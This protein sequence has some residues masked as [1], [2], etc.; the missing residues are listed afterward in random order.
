MMVLECG[1]EA[2]VIDAGLM[3]PEDY[4]FGVDMVL[5]D[6]SY[7]KAKRDKIRAIILTHGH[8][9]H[10]GALP[11]FLEEFKGI[12]IYGTAFT[13]GLLQEKLR[14]QKGGELE[15][16]Y[17]VKPR[18]RV[19]FGPMEVEF[20]RV[21]HS[22]PDCVG[23]GIKTPEGYI[24]HSGDFKLDSSA[25][26]TERTDLRKFAEYGEK[27]VALLLS[28]STNADR[29]GFS[30]SE[31]EVA[32]KLE[33]I[34][35]ERKGRVIVALFAS[36]I[37]RI[38][39]LMEIAARTGR[40]VALVGKNVVANSRLAAELDYLDLPSDGL[41]ELNGIEQAP[42][43]ELLIITTGSQAEPMSALSL[44]ASESHKYLKVREGDTIVLSS[45]FIP[46]NER[47]ITHMIN[48]LCRLGAEVIYS[49]IA[50]VHASGHAHRKELQLL[51]SLVQPRYLLPVHGEYRHLVA[52]RQLAQEMGMEDGRVV[53]AEDGQVIALRDG[54]VTLEGRVEVGKVFV[55]GK[56]IGDVED[57][58][59]RDRRHL[60]EDGMVVPIM[61]VKEQTG[62][63][64]SGPD[65]ITKGVFFEE[66]GGE[67]LERAKERLL[68]MWREITETGRSD[69]TELEEEVRR[70]LKRFFKKEMGR[71]PV[72]IPVIIGM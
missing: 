27:G 46:G 41:V 3:F 14:D 71:R 56:G 62:E 37:R 48:N 23:L 58:V 43:G 68:E 8:E 5:P 36:N 53:L 44:M 16:C 11:F 15:E 30:L 17:V 33:E 6:I 20:I 47:S 1:E 32:R 18:D 40:K 45:R 7:L 50:P 34:V 38:G 65:I 72:I 64:I 59:L 63:I 52:H 28:D 4:M 13:L 54:E 69:E 61:V 55:D 29:D 60:S 67:V 49:E 70:V 10:I 31:R 9:D 19:D 35:R 66:R 26:P 25:P 2:I 12:P 57:V 39:Q 21:C 42:P 51:L 22:I 24:V